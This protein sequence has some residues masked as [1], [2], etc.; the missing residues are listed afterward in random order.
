MTYP[1]ESQQK[2]KKD[3]L[4]LLITLLRANFDVTELEAVCKIT[5]L[6]Y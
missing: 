5:S 2:K 6:L 1:L 4:W 3:S